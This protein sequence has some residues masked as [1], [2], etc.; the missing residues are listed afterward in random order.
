MATCITRAL[1][2]FNAITRR[3]NDVPINFS[4][5]RT[6]DGWIS[7]KR[8]G[9]W[10][11]SRSLEHDFLFTRMLFKSELLRVWEN[12]RWHDTHTRT[13]GQRKMH[14]CAMRHATLLRD[15]LFFFYRSSWTDLSQEDRR[16]KGFRI[17]RFWWDSNGL[18]DITREG[19]WLNCPPAALIQLRGSFTDSTAILFQY[20][21]L[22]IISNRSFS[23]LRIFSWGILNSQES[24]LN[25]FN[26]FPVI[27]RLEK[28]FL[29]KRTLYGYAEWYI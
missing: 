13:K 22:L 20:Q 15:R 9:D 23:S 14:P 28:D 12:I 25:H 21:G 1:E 4:S 17:F 3:R 24:R 11:F 10:N 7:N 6:S 5:A 8:P 27:F 18:R 19:N 16:I 29:L 2:K 26:Q